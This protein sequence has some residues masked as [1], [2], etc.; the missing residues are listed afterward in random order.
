MHWSRG[1]AARRCIRVGAAV[2]AVLAGAVAIV[3][4]PGTTQA[5]QAAAVQSS[6]FNLVL[7][8]AASGG[9]AYDAPAS[10][11]PALQ[12]GAGDVIPASANSTGQSH[13]PGMDHSATD[14]I[15][16]TLD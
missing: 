13:C 14:G 2:V 8:T 11:T 10:C 12:V 6:T 3:A 4:G 15:V 1:R 16:R 7:S 9:G 5:P